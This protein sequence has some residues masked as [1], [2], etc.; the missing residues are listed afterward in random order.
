MSGDLSFDLSKGGGI[1]S[2]HLG[3]RACADNIADGM[4]DDGSQYMGEFEP[5]DD[6]FLGGVLTKGDLVEGNAVSS[7]IEMA[8]NKLLSLIHI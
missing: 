4:S 7:E 5:C 8:L 3:D 2:S 6:D 1:P